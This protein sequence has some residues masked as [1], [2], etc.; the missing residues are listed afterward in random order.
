VERVIETQEGQE[1]PEQVVLEAAQEMEEDSEL[2]LVEEGQELVII[3]EDQEL[4]DL[5]GIMVVQDLEEQ[6]VVQDLEEQEEQAVV[7]DLED[8][9]VV[10]DLE[11]QAVVQDLEEQEVLEEKE[12]LVVV[13][14]L[15]AAVEIK[16]DQ[17]SVVTLDCLVMEDLEVETVWEVLVWE[18]LTM[19]QGEEKNWEDLVAESLPS[20]APYKPAQQ[21]LVNWRETTGT[22]G[23]GRSSDLGDT[24][25]SMRHSA[26]RCVRGPACSD[27][28]QIVP[29]SMSAT[30]I[31]GSR[32]S[33][34]TSS[35]V[36]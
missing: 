8:Q 27:I 12:E 11:E 28:Q 4:E 3:Q 9:A 7:Q 19:T 32:S 17:D 1:D 26:L 14:D 5:E 15:E 25:A 18:I 13:Q 21:S 22:L 33:P 6:E 23:L 24:G 30:G 36:R 10:Q 34:F 20:S 31:N 16:E 35:L 29:S 2:E